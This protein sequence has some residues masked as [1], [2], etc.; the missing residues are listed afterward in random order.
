MK[1]SLFVTSI[2]FLGGEGLEFNPP[3]HFA[4]A[5]NSGRGKQ[6]GSGD[7]EPHAR[8]HFFKRTRMDLDV[9]AALE[10]EAFM[11]QQAMLYKQMVLPNETALHGDIRFFAQEA[12]RCETY[13]CSPCTVERRQFLNVCECDSD[14]RRIFKYLYDACNLVRPGFPQVNVSNFA[15][16]LSSGCVRDEATLGRLHQIVSDARAARDLVELTHEEMGELQI[17]LSVLGREH[18]GVATI[19]DMDNA[20]SEGGF[21]LQDL[22]PSTL[23][24]LRRLV[25][26]LGL[27]R[28][29][30]DAKRIRASEERRRGKKAKR[31][32]SDVLGRKGRTQRGD[33]SPR[34]VGG[35]KAVAAH[36][37]GKVLAAHGDG[38]A[39]A[40][41]GGG[42]AMWVRMW[43][44]FLD[45]CGKAGEFRQEQTLT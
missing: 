10:R 39:V 24:K 37:G 2:H 19:L 13:R 32:E 1:L 11:A 33:L 28:I 25:W 27:V 16:L 43:R 12:S 17:V 29:A 9:A 44:E 42:K 22:A 31:R 36:G 41:H 4:R 3:P 40:A 14:R 26:D 8:I 38:K 30:T 34:G 35:G 23:S 5:A 45:G 6:R 20:A 7:N 21:S 18:N 15:T